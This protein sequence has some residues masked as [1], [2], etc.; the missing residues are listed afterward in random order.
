M[1]KDLN[2]LFYGGPGGGQGWVVTDTTTTDTNQLKIDGAEIQSFD[3]FDLRQ[4]IP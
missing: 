1:Y 2:S 4:F 3:G